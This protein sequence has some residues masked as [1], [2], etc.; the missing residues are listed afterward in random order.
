MPVPADTCNK[1]R[2]KEEEKKR[3][4]KKEE[5]E[6]KRKEEKKKKKATTASVKTM[7]FKTRDGQL[8][9]RSIRAKS[10]YQSRV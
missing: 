8:E 4:K 5:K 2:I 3:I 1:K 10:E 7:K 9:D 6:K